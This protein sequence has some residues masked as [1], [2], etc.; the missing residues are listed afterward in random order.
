MYNP[1]DMI[2]NQ[3]RIQKLQQVMTQF[4]QSTNVGNA[5]SQNHEGIIWFSGGTDDL[6]YTTS[7]GQTLTG[8][9]PALMQS[10]NNI[11]QGTGTTYQPPMQTAQLQGWLP[12][13]GGRPGSH[14]ILVFVTDGLDEDPNDQAL[15]TATANNMR[16]NMGVTIY[17]IGIS[18]ITTYFKGLMDIANQPS[19][20]Y[21]INA[22]Q[23]A[24]L[25]NMFN[26]IAAGVQCG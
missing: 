6:Y 18:N 25:D 13:N 3:L 24:D 21:F 8:S 26:K 2:G 22:T 5:K 19:S 7:P 11:S 4:V 9:I 17:S 10:I 15:A 1:N 20:T 16:N 23:P 12:N 14:K